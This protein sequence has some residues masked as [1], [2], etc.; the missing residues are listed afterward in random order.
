[1]LEKKTGFTLIELIVVIAI[2]SILSVSVVANYRAGERQLALERSAYQL[3]QDVR[4]AQAMAMAATK[5]PAST[6]C[7]GEVPLGGYGL[8]LERNNNYYFLYADINNNEQYDS[9]EEVETIYFETGVV[10]SVS[11]PE[12]FSINFRPPD[13]KIT[14]NGTDQESQAIVINLELEQSKTKTITVNKVGLIEIE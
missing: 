1:M 8:Y 2:I 12:F 11:S 7:A 13:P 3:S 9:G 10:F 6:A 5:C 4:K 14:I